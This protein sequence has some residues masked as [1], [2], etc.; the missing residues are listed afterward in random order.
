MSLDIHKTFPNMKTTSGA[1]QSTALI[2]DSL[3]NE[4]QCAMIIYT[5]EPL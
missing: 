1:V 5:I 2:K 3:A 4:E